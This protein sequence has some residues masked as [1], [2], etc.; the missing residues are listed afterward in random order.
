MCKGVRSHTDGR[1]AEVCVCVCVKTYWPPPLR[2]SASPE[3]TVT[4]ERTIIKIH[5][6]QEINLTPPLPSPPSFS[7]HHSS[8]HA[9]LCPSP[10][11]PFYAISIG[12]FLCLKFLQIFHLPSLQRAEKVDRGLL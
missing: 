9:S 3:P 5:S 12:H 8:L 1:I 2:K 4:P 11:L 7:S 10:P 6:A